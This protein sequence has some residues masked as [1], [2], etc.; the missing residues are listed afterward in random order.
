MKT[1]NPLVASRIFLFALMLALFYL[2]LKVKMLT[3]IQVA[4]H[5]EKVRSIHEFLEIRF[6]NRQYDGAF[7]FHF[8]Q[9]TLCIP[10]AASPADPVFGKDDAKLAFRCAQYSCKLQYRRDVRWLF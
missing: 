2:S 1:Q 9:F 5:R 7:G 3:F 6:R 10:H 8:E 4:Q